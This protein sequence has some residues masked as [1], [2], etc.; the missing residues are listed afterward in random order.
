MIE[1]DCSGRRAG[2]NVASIT[3]FPSRITRAL[4]PAL[5]IGSPSQKM[6]D[7][8]LPAMIVQGDIDEAVPVTKTRMKE[9]KLVIAAG[10][11]DIFAFFNAHIKQG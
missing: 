7:V 9:M 6:K 2:T 8:N 11:P 4:T 1:P 10:M 5:T 3:G